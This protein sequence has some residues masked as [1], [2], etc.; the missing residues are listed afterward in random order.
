MQPESQ[1][2][3]RVAPAFGMLGITVLALFTLLCRLESKRG[4]SEGQP[5]RPIT[6][7]DRGSRGESPSEIELR[8]GRKVDVATGRARV[9][10]VLERS[11]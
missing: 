8:E 4:M 11:K 10:V 1:R 6:G 2:V 5:A 3:V 9:Q 7:G